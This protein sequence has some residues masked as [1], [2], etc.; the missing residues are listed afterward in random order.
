MERV[1]YIFFIACSITLLEAQ[2]TADGCVTCAV[3]DFFKAGW[4]DWILPAAGKL[5]FLLPDSEPAPD[6]TFPKPEPGKQ[7]TNN[8]PGNINQPA[9]E[10]IVAD[11]DRKCSSNGAAVSLR[12]F[13]LIDILCS[14]LFLYPT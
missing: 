13:T 1:C 5:Q 8:S 10:E 14:D 11:P 7:G 4:E 3:G 6:T 9:I 12:L 2:G